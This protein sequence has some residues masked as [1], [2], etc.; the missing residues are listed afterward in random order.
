[1]IRTVWKTPSWITPK[2]IL[3]EGILRLLR[4]TAAMAQVE[5]AIYITRACDLV[6]GPSLC[7]L[8][9]LGGSL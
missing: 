2:E 7:V 8:E 3:Q 6:S 5:N 9:S 1:M 4:N